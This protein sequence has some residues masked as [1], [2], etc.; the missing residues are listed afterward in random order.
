MTKQVKCEWLKNWKEFLIFI[1]MDRLQLAQKSE[2][3]RNAYSSGAKTSHSKIPFKQC[4][5]VIFLCARN[6][7]ILH[8]PTFTKSWAVSPKLLHN[9]LISACRP[10]KY[11][12]LRFPLV[13]QVYIYHTYIKIRAME[14]K[15]SSCGG[16]I[17]YILNS[18]KHCIPFINI[19]FHDFLSD[20][21]ST[22]IPVR[23]K[24]SSS[25]NR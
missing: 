5:L 6:P 7:I 10:V 16:T 15:M 22:C 21:T 3:L 8:F 19:A 2:K 18:A 23:G 4:S 25:S 1:M 20:E 14:V 12:S 24:I 11:H 9:M 17:V 13:V